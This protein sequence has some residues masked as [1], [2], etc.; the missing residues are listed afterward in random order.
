MDTQIIGTTAI[1]LITI[2]L[3]VPLGKYIAEIT[4]C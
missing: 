2:L 1:F 3:A 4:P